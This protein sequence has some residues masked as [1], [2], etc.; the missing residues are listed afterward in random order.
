MSNEDVTLPRE[1]MR[2]TLAV[3]E[4][5]RCKLHDVNLRVQWNQRKIRVL[6]EMRERLDSDGDS[7][8]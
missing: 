6:R 3:L 7:G 2:E 5:A 1:M 4:D 8:D